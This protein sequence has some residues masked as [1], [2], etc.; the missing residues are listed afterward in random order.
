MVEKVLKRDGSVQEF[1]KQKIEDAVFKAIIAAG[2]KDKTGAI[3]IAKS[4]EQELMIRFADRFPNV[5]DIQDI[6][7]RHL[8]KAG[9]DRV[10][11]A[12]I[13]Y[14]E[15]RRGARED[16]SLA[17]ATI[18]MFT[19]Y[20]AEDDYAVKNNANMQKSVAGLINHVNE[21]FTKKY[22]LNEIYTADIA[23]AHLS[24]AM[25]LHDLGFFGAYCV[26]W[27]LKQVLLEGYRGPVGKISSLP[28]KHLRAFLGQV[29]NCTFSTQFETAG[30][31][32]WSSFDTY[33]APFVRADNLTYKQVKQCLQEFVFNL[34]VATRVGFQT[35]FSNLT[36]DIT[37]PKT[38]KDEHAIIGGIP[39]E[40]KYGDYQAEMDMINIAFCEV[41]LDG[42]ANG[43]VFSFPIPTINVTRELDWNSEVMNKWIELTCK[44]GVPYFA[45]YI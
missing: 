29:V 6:V 33:I 45:N 34:N 18:N 39:Q 17:G 37:C 14:R 36:F 26:G 22:W 35:P 43:R 10:A 27:D 5:E 3:N 24:G 8:I 4:V 15:K 23:N 12:Y 31:Q 40:E 21:E 16:N 7:E 41:M 42:D 13:L 20:L 25:H 2:G 28:A 32:A 19:K 9:H 1:S 38:L 30:A 44:Y 11:K